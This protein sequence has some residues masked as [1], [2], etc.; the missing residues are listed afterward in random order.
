M[1]F[2][3]KSHDCDSAKDVW[4]ALYDIIYQDK[5]GDMLNFTIKSDKGTSDRCKRWYIKIDAD[6]QPALRKRFPTFKM[7]GDCIFNFNHKKIKLFREIIGEQENELLAMCQD[8]HHSLVNFSFMPITG[9]L[10][11]T[12]G[13]LRCENGIEKKSFDR[14]DVLIAELEKF[15]KGVP[16]RVFRNT[17]REALEWYLNL[18]AERGIAGYCKDIYLFDDEDMLQRFLKLAKGPISDSDTA[19][20]YMELARDYWK[21]KETK[22]MEYGI[23]NFY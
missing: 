4:M 14:P 6:K 23:T 2:S 10:N 5:F 7:A 22:L 8:H 16:A 18:F 17:N 15:Y 12:K 3:D 21:M 1:I 19:I 9:G 11:N 13:T 20:E